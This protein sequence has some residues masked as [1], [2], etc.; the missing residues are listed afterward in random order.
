VT[1]PRGLVKR[2][3]SVEDDSLVAALKEEWSVAKTSREQ[4]ERR[5]AELEGIERDLHADQAEVEALLETW[6]SWQ[7]TLLATIDGVVPSSIPAETQAQAR[8]ILQKVVV[9]R[10][11][12]LPKV[13]GTWSFSGYARFEGVLRG[14]LARGEVV[15][16]ERLNGSLNPWSRQSRGA[17]R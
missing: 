11:Y 13:D 4:A 15:V 16:T 17:P 9:G 6:R 1:R 12:V 2:I 14:G 7:V 3:A 5:L 10:L 8:Q